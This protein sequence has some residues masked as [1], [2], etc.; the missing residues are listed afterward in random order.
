MK[1]TTTDTSTED[2]FTLNAPKKNANGE[3]KQPLM[4]SKQTKTC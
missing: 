1:M 2:E 4:H 3:T